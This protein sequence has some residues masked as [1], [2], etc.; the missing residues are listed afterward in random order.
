MNIQG[1]LRSENGAAVL[2]LEARY[3][4]TVADV[5]AALTEP[6]RI[7]GWYGNVEGD[8]RV[9]GDF[10][11]TVPMSG[12]EGTGHVSVCDPLGHLV[13]TTRENVESYEGG[14]GAAPFDDVIDV[15]LTDEGATTFVVAEFKGLP[16]DK[17]EYYGAGWQMHAESLGAYLAGTEPPGEE[18][19]DELV[20]FYQP[21]AAALRQAS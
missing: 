3:E 21:L 9:G 17:V 19:F 18:R 1:S 2:L 6:A 5:W 13:V 8:L 7:S 16:L 10:R 14:Q 12:W 11:L 15:R 20:P 4:A